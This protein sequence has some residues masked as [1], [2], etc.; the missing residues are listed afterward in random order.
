MFLKVSRLTTV[1]LIILDI[2]ILK[3]SARTSC[4]L[5]PEMCKLMPN[6]SW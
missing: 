1:V 3:H 2:E 6:I 4:T 5:L